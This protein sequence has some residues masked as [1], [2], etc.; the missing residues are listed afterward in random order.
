MKHALEKALESFQPTLPMAVAFSGGA[1]STALLGACHSKW[2]GQVRAL[3]INHGLQ[4]AAVSFEAHCK[5]FCSERNIP[6]VVVGVNAKHVSGQSPEDAARRARYR[7]IEQALED[8]WGGQVR[9]VALA[10]HA[11]DQIETVILALSRGA[12]LPGLSGMRAHWVSAGVRFHRPIMNVSVE[13]LRQYNRTHDLPWVEDPTN[14]DTRFTRNK[15]RQLIL[16]PLQGAFP[17]FAS[18]LARS[19]KHIAQAQRLLEALAQM[20]LKDVG[21]PPHI[22]SLQALEPDR[23]GNVLRYWLVCEG[24]QA[25]DAQMQELMHQIRSCQTRG[26]H[27]ELKVGNA[28][29]IRMEQSLALATIDGL[30]KT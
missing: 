13:D 17:E 26:H 21:N 11:Q 20:D 24:C 27:I 12:G 28:K 14:V 15:I 3:H 25:S 18:M 8:H 1:D 4:D 29:V 6:L 19:A 16:P 22:K 23:M 9:D 10:Q 7:A 30:L 2:P 5:A